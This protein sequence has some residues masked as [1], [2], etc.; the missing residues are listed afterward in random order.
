[1][2]DKKFKMQKK[3]ILNIECVHNYKLCIKYLHDNKN[4]EIRDTTLPNTL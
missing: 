1:M 2:H 3:N 4:E